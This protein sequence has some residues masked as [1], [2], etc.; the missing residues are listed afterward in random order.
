MTVSLEKGTLDCLLPR[1]KVDSFKW[2]CDNIR[3][4]NGDPFSP[5]DYPWTEG[6][7]KEWDNPDRTTLWMQF[8]ARAGKTILACSLLQCAIYTAPAPALFGTSTGELAKQSI[9]KRLIPMFE[10]SP[11]RKWLPP[12]HRRRQTRLD[13]KHST[14]YVSWSGSATTL[15]DIGPKYKW[16]NEVD[17]WTKDKSEEADPLELFGERGAEFPNRKE[18][19]ESTPTITGTSRVNRG[20]EMG[21]NCRFLV[22]CPHCG[23]Y[24]QFVR[25]DGSGGGLVWEKDSDGRSTPDLA[26]ETARYRCDKCAR[27]IHD[28]QRM[29]MVRKGIWCPEGCS[30][31]KNGKLSGTPRNNGPHASFQLSRAYSPTFTFGDFARAWIAAKDDREKLRNFLNSW[32]GE[33]YTPLATRFT[34]DETAELLCR[35]YRLGTVPSGGCFVTA[36]IDVQIDHYV[37]L[38]CAW[39]ENGTG[40]VIDYGIAHDPHELR[41]EFLDYMYECEDGGELPVSFTLMDA[42][43]NTE[44]I[45]SLCA[46]LSREGRYVMPSMGSKPGT[47]QGRSFRR[48]DMDDHG[49]KTARRRRGSTQ[50]LVTVNTNYW[51]SWLQNC[52]ERR[53]PGDEGS[54]AFPMDAREDIDLWEQLLNEAETENVGTTGHTTTQWCVVNRSIPVD[55]RDAARYCRCAAEVRLNGAWNR[56]RARRPRTKQAVQQTPTEK[57]KVKQRQQQT[58]MQF[59]DRPG[60]WANDWR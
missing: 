36:G 5:H 31:R 17:K 29:D 32:E 41:T 52:L 7:C 2:I 19:Y 59:L 47:M 25:G 56:V 39:G 26:W 28:E 11:L 42:G 51:Q 16:G 8:A 34:W 1:P 60:G 14:V 49:K 4:P 48:Q 45:K 54:L 20:L 6:I 38:A 35:D 18:I 21:T 10:Q 53:R 23:H 33:T 27:D 30:V 15:A 37:Y 13:L 50:Q 58:S 3:L 43:F 44:E 57:K 24:Q 9:V 46:S 55:F 22:P 12:E 40:W